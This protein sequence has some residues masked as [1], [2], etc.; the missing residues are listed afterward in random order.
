MLFATARSTMTLHEPATLATDYALTAIAA[1]LARRLHQHTPSA[2]FAARWWVWTLILTAVAAFVGGSYH[3]FGPNLPPGVA[4]H[5]WLVTL[6]LVCLISAA[7]S[8]SWIFEMIRPAA[9]R[10][11]FALVVVKLLAFA[12]VA[13]LRPSFA[14]VILDYG[15]SI[16]LW[17]GAAL[18]LRRA[19]RTWMIAATVLSIAGALVQLLRLAPAS[20]FNHN[21]LY[22][23]IQFLGVAAFYRAA[24][25][26]SPFTP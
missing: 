25:R 14:V 21:D 1:W 6:W 3:G 4:A 15:L 17:L 16:L 2:N 7:M 9:Q 8:A 20:W 23:V 24:R 12:V 26:L 5:W 13:V 18:V 11:G 10:A 22:H 19:W